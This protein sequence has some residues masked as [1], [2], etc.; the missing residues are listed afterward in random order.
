MQDMPLTRFR[1]ESDFFSSYIF[2]QKR[3]G[4]NPCGSGVRDS[5]ALRVKRQA[6]IENLSGSVP[7]L[8]FL[9]DTKHL[10]AACIRISDRCPGV[11]CYG[12]IYDVSW[13]E[14]VQYPFR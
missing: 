1:G 3:R 2:L 14:K 6:D 12:L 7:V 4:H 9:F 11:V 13:P 10:P 8:P 5:R